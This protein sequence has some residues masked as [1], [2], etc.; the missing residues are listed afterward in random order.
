MIQRRLRQ[1]TQAT[2]VIFLFFA[3]ASAV[4]FEDGLMA[5]FHFRAALI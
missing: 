2:Q 5:F 4:Q 3:Q 1:E